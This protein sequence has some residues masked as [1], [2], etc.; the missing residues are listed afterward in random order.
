MVNLHVEVAHIADD[1]K[2]GEPLETNVDF[3][4][5]AEIKYLVLLSTYGWRP[6]KL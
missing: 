4:S 2:L 3:G 6:V 5:V 1:Q